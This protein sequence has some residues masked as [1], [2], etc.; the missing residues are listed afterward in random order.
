MTRCFSQPHSRPWLD[1]PQKLFFLFLLTDA[2]LLPYTH[3]SIILQCS[4]ESPTCNDILNMMYI[5]CLVGH[6]RLWFVYDLYIFDVFAG[7]YGRCRFVFHTRFPAENSLIPVLCLDSYSKI[8]AGHSSLFGKGGITR[9]SLHCSSQKRWVRYGF[10]LR[11]NQEGYLSFPLHVDNIERERERKKKRSCQIS[12]VSCTQAHGFHLSQ[13]WS[14][15]HRNG[16]DCSP[17]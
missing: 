16:T 10:C 9:E 5:A 17:R 12:R 4:S 13:R 6:C 11:F 7:V 1:N 2:S 14:A 15:G 8:F 3:L